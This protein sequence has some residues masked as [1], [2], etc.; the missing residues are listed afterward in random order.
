M[1]YNIQ[2]RP[3]VVQPPLPGEHVRQCL[4]GLR[5]VCFSFQLNVISIKPWNESVVVSALCFITSCTVLLKPPS[6][7]LSNSGSVQ[8]STLKN[9]FWLVFFF[10]CVFI[11]VNTLN[12]T[13][14]MSVQPSKYLQ[15]CVIFLQNQ[16]A[17]PYV[18]C[19]VSAA[20]PPTAC[21]WFKVRIICENSDWSS[22]IF[23]QYVSNEQGW[24]VFC[25]T[26]SCST[27]QRQATLCRALQST[28]RPFQRA[29]YSC[30]SLMTCCCHVCGVCTVYKVRR[31]KNMSSLQ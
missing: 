31:S 6:H 15:R 30:M 8:T 18:V 21:C 27:A 4:R 22:L 13:K 17:D 10:V 12:Q 25:F 14:T 11:S 19:A 28:F 16:D 29:F 1:Q 26:I 7:Y 24:T 5:S 2:N 23:A 20:L 3:P 9:N